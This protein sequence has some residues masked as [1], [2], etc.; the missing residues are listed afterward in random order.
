[1]GNSPSAAPAPVS[2]PA[3]APNQAAVPAA[4]LS[5]NS[6]RN[7]SKTVSEVPVQNMNATKGGKRRRTHKRKS[8][9]HKGRRH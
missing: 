3:P 4:S 8:R 5:V 2:A 6:K 9:K 7:N 1:M